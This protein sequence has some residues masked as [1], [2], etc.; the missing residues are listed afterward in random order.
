MINKKVK[1]I[2][3]DNEVS[4][5][6]KEMTKND[7]RKSIVKAELVFAFVAFA[8]PFIMALAYVFVSDNSIEEVFSKAYRYAF[9]GVLLFFALNIIGSFYFFK[10]K[11]TKQFGKEICVISTVLA[12][13]FIV[14][15]IFADYISMF[16]AP[17]CIIGLMIALLI[18]GNLAL[19]VNT[20]SVVAF[21]ICY[22]S[23][24]ND[25]ELATVLSA[26][27]TQ[28]VGGCFLILISKKVYTRISFFV[29]SLLVS[30]LVAFP[31]AF[32]SG[33]LRLG[34]GDISEIIVIA[35]KNG[36]WSLVSFVLGLSVFMVCLPIFEFLFGMYS[37][38]R[39]DEICAPDA[40]LMAKLAK[41]APGTYNHSL[42]MANLAQA[43]AMA[44]GENVALARAGACYHDV[45]KLRNP[46]CFTENQTDY[47]PHDD[48]IPEVSVSLITR[49]P[50]DGA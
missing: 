5:A 32:V 12:I 45:G 14:G 28:A 4:I 50:S 37:N 34:E 9:L 39:L 2:D 43:C 35:L 18:D 46:I 10:R 11:I 8:L 23:F 1:G 21:Y 16:I 40:P 17:I 20:V 29:D 31:I 6:P 42:A 47:N 27:F 22:C 26:I 38:F 44:I 24:G 41:E 49:H 19:Y 3:F 15:T 13:T 36:L 25:Y 30:L 33:L 7:K 48:Y